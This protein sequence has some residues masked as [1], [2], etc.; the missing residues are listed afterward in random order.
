MKSADSSA[1]RASVRNAFR[2]GAISRI[3]VSPLYP[4]EKAVGRCSALPVL[5]EI[6][7]LWFQHRTPPAPRT[8]PVAVR[9]CRR[10]G[11]CRRKRRSSRTRASPPSKREKHKTNPISALYAAANKNAKRTH[12]SS[13]SDKPR[14]TKA[15]TGSEPSEGDRVPVPLLRDGASCEAPVLA[16][17]PSAYSERSGLALAVAPEKQRMKRWRKCGQECGLN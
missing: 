14:K 2:V 15:P 4:S 16:A 7:I 11:P 3:V 6:Y 9:L 12:A 8:A 5:S 17:C 10:E 1:K 13:L